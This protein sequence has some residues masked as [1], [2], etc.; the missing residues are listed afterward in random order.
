MGAGTSLLVGFGGR[1]GDSWLRYYLLLEFV[2]GGYDR[3]HFQNFREITLERGI[4]EAGIGLRIVAPL[5]PAFRW[6][7]DVELA[8]VASDTEFVGSHVGSYD[9]SELDGA[10]RFATGF[11]IR[12]EEWISAGLRLAATTAFDDFDSDGGRGFLI[13]FESELGFY[14]AGLAVTF[15]F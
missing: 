2:G 5:F 15:Y 14:D 9:S 12:P 13:G 10:M 11:Q 1:P 3:T 7:G 8:L 4:I 6:F